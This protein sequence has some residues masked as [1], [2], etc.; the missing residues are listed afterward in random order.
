MSEDE[1]DP[2]AEIVGLC[3]T[4]FEPGWKAPGRGR[5]D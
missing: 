4:S 3:H 1:P 5:S 2:W